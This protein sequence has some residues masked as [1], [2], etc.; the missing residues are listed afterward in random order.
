MKP[1]ITIE[2]LPEDCQIEGNCS[3]ID[4][5][6]D[7]Q[8]AEWIRDQLNRGN[9]W[10]WC[11]VKVM[12]TIEVDGIPFSGCDYLGCCSYESEESFKHPDGYYPDMIS[13]AI[14]DLRA[15]LQSA[16]DHGRLAAQAIKDLERQG[17]SCS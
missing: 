3:A 4:P 12:A 8:T 9:E 5:E 2:C 7:R 15:S 1:T 16:V 17:A 13:E 10:A 11:C 6:T 14:D